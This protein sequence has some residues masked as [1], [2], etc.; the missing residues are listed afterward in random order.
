MAEYDEMQPGDVKYRVVVEK[1]RAG[2]YTVTTADGPILLKYVI[3]KARCVVIG[4]YQS[5]HDGITY[6]SRAATE[7]DLFDDPETLNPENFV[8]RATLD[9]EEGK[10]LVVAWVEARLQQVTARLKGS[11]EETSLLAY[12]KD[13]IFQ[14]IAEQIY[15]RDHPRKVSAVQSLVPADFDWLNKPTEV[16]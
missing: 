4:E 16:G 13:M 8:S 6:T 14:A 11:E 12:Y 9:S 2:N 10:A 5:A 1:A 3:S 7:L 15:R